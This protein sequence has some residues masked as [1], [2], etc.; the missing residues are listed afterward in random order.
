MVP[1]DYYPSRMLEE[2]EIDWLV[3]SAIAS[4]INLLRIWGGGVYLSDYFYTKADRAGLMIWHDLMF[5]CKVY[6]T[7]SQ[8]FVQN[9]KIETREQVGRIAY[10]PSVVFWDLNNEG[11]AMIFWDSSYNVT[12]MKEEY[13]EFY[14]D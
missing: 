14:V 13:K 6:P 10:H 4:N 2:T 8:A 12:F 11:E 9:S 5:S 3:D 7:H 1:M